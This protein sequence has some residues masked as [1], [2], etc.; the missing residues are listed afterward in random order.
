MTALG[1]NDSRE[2]LFGN[3]VIGFLLAMGP[4]CMFVE[5]CV[6]VAR[7]GTAA[8]GGKEDDR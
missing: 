5:D 2:V 4:E 3:S 8:C 6:G 7:T 1:L